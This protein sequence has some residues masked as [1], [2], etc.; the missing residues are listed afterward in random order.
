MAKICWYSPAII[1]KALP[2]LL[3]IGAV[4]ITIMF[5]AEY[6]E[7]FFLV[8]VLWITIP[9]LVLWITI[10]VLAVQFYRKIKARFEKR[11]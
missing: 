7:A 5:L 9:V 1:K 2:A 4:F 11:P 8:L 3:V 6:T 10:P